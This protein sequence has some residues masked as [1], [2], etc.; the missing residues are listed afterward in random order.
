[1]ALVQTHSS[2]IGKGLYNYESMLAN[3]SRFL[4]FNA[5]SHQI[6]SQIRLVSMDYAKEIIE[7]C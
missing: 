7:A 3:H 5:V 2:K 4:E 6:D 1:M